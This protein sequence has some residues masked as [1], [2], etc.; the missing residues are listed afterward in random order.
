VP[1]VM[2]GDHERCGRFVARL[3]FLA[4]RRRWRESRA[5]VCA[6]V[7]DTDSERA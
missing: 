3:L 4:A 6:V 5:L 7:A 1:I 2:A